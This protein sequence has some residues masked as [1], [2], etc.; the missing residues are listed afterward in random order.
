MLARN[1]GKILTGYVLV[2]KNKKSDQDC[3]A[4]DKIGSEKG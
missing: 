1:F 3:D 2:V 4:V